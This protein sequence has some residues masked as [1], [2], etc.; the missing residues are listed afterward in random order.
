M[1]SLRVAVALA[2]LVL[3]S[4][5]ANADEPPPTRKLADAV[6]VEAG[7]CLEPRAMIDRIAMW[8]GRDEIDARLEGVLRSDHDDLVFSLKR[9]GK[10]VGERHFARRPND[11]CVQW[12]AAV[13]LAV[14]VALDSTLLHSLGVLPPVATPP[15]P[16]PTP[17]A[18]PAPPPPTP[19]APPNPKPVEPV[20]GRPTGPRPAPALG[21]DFLVGSIPDG[22]ALGARARLEIP[23]GSG[24]E[25]GVAG[26]GSS[27][28][29]E[30]DVSLSPGTLR[31][32]VL[33]G[34]AYVCLHWSETLARP[35]VCLGGEGGVLGV[36]PSGLLRPEKLRL[37]WAA[38]WGRVELR[39]P[40]AR[41]WNFDVG[42]EPFASVTRPRLAVASL[43]NEE[44][45]LTQRQI[46]AIGVALSA[47][48]AFTF[49]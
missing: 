6:H 17:P 46:P 3:F 22:T 33:A 14:A 12:T 26:M 18:P 48:I 19:F 9:E 43:E 8:L 44:Q 4:G 10:P 45:I 29:G 42:I 36:D 16:P 13:S 11:S 23:L 37:P 20:D 24:V 32:S 21:V 41:R 15:P 35:R 30:G 25:V 1:R 47:G 34:A 39:F 31:L 38:A 49:W 40:L 7:P 2:G 27:T 5:R 28:V